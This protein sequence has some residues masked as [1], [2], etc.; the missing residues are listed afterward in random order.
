MANSSY[1]ITEM[2]LP[3]T[4]MKHNLFL[5]ITIMNAS[6]A[7]NKTYQ[8]ADGVDSSVLEAVEFVEVESSIT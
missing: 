8:A 5:T 3:K 7:N 6:K 2:K 4:H 1:H